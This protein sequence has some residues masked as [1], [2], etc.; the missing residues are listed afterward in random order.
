MMQWYQ[1][2]MLSTASCKVKQYSIIMLLVCSMSGL[3]QAVHATSIGLSQ[4]QYGL[5]PVL[6]QLDMP[7][8]VKS[9]QQSRLWVTLMSGQ[10]VVT[11]P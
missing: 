4:T 10:V 9:D 1:F 5:Y 11:T 3:S 7:W 2:L 6:S 8:A